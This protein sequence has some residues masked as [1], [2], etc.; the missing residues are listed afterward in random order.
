MKLKILVI[1]ILP[2]SMHERTMLWR[3]MR[4]LI[5]TVVGVGFF[6]LPFVFAQAGFLLALA[7]L[8][9][10][11]GIQIL[12][13]RMYADLLLSHSSH[14]RFLHVVAEAFGP[15]GKMFAIVAFFGS[16]WGAMVAYLVAGGD[17][18]AQFFG[19]F[20]HVSSHGLSI[21][22]GC[23]LWL[24]LLG[25]SSVVSRLQRYLVPA[26]LCIF[27]VLFFFLAPYV[28]ISY[29]LD[30]RLQF[31][32]L[33]L[34]VILFSLSAISVIPEMRDEVSRDSRALH[35]AISWG[36]AAVAALYVLFAFFIVGVAGLET[37]EQA[38]FALRSFAPW[39]VTLGSLLGIVTISSAY[40]HVGSAL[41]HTLL[42]DF[43]L[44]YF[45]SWLLI[46]GVPF[47]VILLG[48]ESLVRVLQFTGGVL[49]AFLGIIVLLAYEKARRLHQLSLH[50]L[51]VSPTIVFGLFVVFFTMLVM[52]LRSI[53]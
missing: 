23:L 46:G 43:R 21:A 1:A 36:I 30:V 29:I 37:P 52:T 45:S 39:M 38:L 53:L 49:G 40:I 11:A 33:P 18:L 44:R 41:I 8:V 15:F 12:F 19:N 22:F 9:F 16:F 20:F 48:V 35:R 51:H 13:L 17:F 27:G 34:G 47:V 10:L 14:A 28:D 6:G 32:S 2:L 5:G 42:F 50:A 4:P 31:W 7:E 26:A 25:G 3:G 24:L